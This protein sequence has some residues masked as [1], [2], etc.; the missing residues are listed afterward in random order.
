M[1]IL[2]KWRTSRSIILTSTRT[3][4]L[5][6]GMWCCRRRSRSWCPSLTWCR[7]MSGAASGCSR[8]RAGST[9][10]SMDR[11]RIFFSSGDRW[12][13]GKFRKW[14]SKRSWLEMLS[15]MDLRFHVI[16][17]RYFV[18][19]RIANLLSCNT[20]WY[21]RLS[22]VNIEPWS[23]VFSLKMLAKITFGSE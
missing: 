9:T 4:N 15:D 22:Q 10:C 11:S 12:T 7:R 19:Y 2:R 17:R 1:Y 18:K 5:S 23:L 21:P 20:L 6:I 14:R 13:M 8:V 16:S 3:M